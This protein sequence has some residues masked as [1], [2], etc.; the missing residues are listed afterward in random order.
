MQID[1]CREIYIYFCICMYGY[2]FICV[3]FFFFVVRLSLFFENNS[4][5][6]KQGLYVQ[7]YMEPKQPRIEQEQQQQQKY[8]IKFG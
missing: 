6:N 8:R 1:V 5:N 3:L 7:S 4:G 2:L